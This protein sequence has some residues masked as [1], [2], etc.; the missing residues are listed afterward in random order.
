[1]HPVVAWTKGT[2][3][4]PFLAA[5]DGDA[6]QAFVADYSARIA[7]AYPALPDGRVLFAVPARFHRRVRERCGKATRPIRATRAGYDG[8]ASRCKIRHERAVGG[9]V[10]LAARTAFHSSQA[11]RM[12]H[13]DRPSRSSPRPR[14]FAIRACS[15][16]FAMPPR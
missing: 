5:L 14:T 7:V 4:T 3:L 11:F 10:P 15:P 16:G 8:A 1:M 9:N 6:Q 12:N 2:A 13:P